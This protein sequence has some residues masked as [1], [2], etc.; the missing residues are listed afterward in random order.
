M[1][2]LTVNVIVD[3]LPSLATVASAA[4]PPAA[5][6]ETVATSWTATRSRTRLGRATTVMI[7]LTLLASVTNYGSNIIFSRLL[8]PSSYGDL[9]AL[10]AFSVIA[11]VPTGA[12]Q[13]IVAER[14]AVLQAE[15]NH[16]QARYLIRHAMAHVAMIALI[17]GLIYAACIP[18]IKPALG[19]QA[20]GPAIALAPLL[21]LSFLIPVAFGVLQGMERF[22]ALGAL[23]LLVAISRIAIGVPW[24]LAGG[25]AG[26]PLFGQAI[27]CL[28]AIGAT[29]LLSRRYLLGRGSGAARAGL[30]RRPDR[31]TMTAGGVFVAFALISN[32][33][34]LL[35]K[36]MLSPH[37]AGEYAA[38]VTIEKIVIF[39]PGAVAVVM[40]PSAAKARHAD[41]S[42]GRVLRIAALLVTSATLLV[43]IPA[44]LA[45]HLLLQLMFGDKYVNAAA[46]VAPIVCAGAGLALLYL[47]AVYTVAIQDRRWVWLLIAG[48]V[49]QVSAIGLLHSSPTQ[50][51]TVQAGVVIAVLIANEC[52]FHPILRA[53][54]LFLSRARRPTSVGS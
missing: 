47:L 3:K 32:L 10:I 34:V 49:L 38:L 36:I 52:I 23:L 35:A 16:D 21:V 28:L 40:V 51:A 17:L 4:D 2:T 1:S 53:E 19:L 46:G 9:T 27:G 33:D 30:R 37:A 20:I 26:G 54:R 44:A 41:G 42:A 6:E 25:G 45:P 11:A 12:A 7:G 31:R 43:A 48:V 8:S 14:I 39:L 50:I 29:A 13:T 24:T 15:G 5:Q 18:L 22:V